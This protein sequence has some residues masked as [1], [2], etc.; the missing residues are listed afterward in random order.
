M[1]VEATIWPLNTVVDVASMT[2]VVGIENE[3]TVGVIVDVSEAGS[4]ASV[5]PVIECCIIWP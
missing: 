5:A 2:M 4:A 1:V 3:L